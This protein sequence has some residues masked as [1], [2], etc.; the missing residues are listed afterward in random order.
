[1]GDMAQK[2]GHC[3]RACVFTLLLAVAEAAYDQQLLFGVKTITP[4]RLFHK[5]TCTIGLCSMKLDPDETA[6]TLL[7]YP[8]GNMTEGTVT[9]IVVGC[10]RVFWGDSTSSAV[11]MAQLH[12]GVL[13]STAEVL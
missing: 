3:A 8:C 12:E 11:M 4:A 2:C 6:R 5:Q 7:E 1:M 9:G 13:A 10:G